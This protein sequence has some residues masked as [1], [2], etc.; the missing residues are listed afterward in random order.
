MNADKIVR[1]LRDAFG[2]VCKS[3]KAEAKGEV[4]E[5]TV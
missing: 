2:G 1:A 3:D 5:R 4:D